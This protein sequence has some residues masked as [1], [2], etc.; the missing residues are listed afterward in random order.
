MVR[1]VKP[2]ICA[3]SAEVLPRAAQVSVYLDPTSTRRCSRNHADGARGDEQRPSGLS[4][5]IERFGGDGAGERQ[6]QAGEE[7]KP[8]G[9]GS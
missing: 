5:G 7:E 6:E 8:H 1:L 2:R 4:A 9:A 3:I